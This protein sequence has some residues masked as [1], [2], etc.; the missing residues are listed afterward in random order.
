MGYKAKTPPC[1]KTCNAG[2]VLLVGTEPLLQVT[3]FP[4][5]APGPDGAAVLLTLAS[6]SHV[7]V[8]EAPS[9]PTPLHNSSVN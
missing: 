3:L 6:E 5:D 7:M 9:F 4:L 8:I 2:S 1:N